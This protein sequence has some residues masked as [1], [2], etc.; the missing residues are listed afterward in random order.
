MFP[1]EDHNPPNFTQIE[2]FCKSV[3]SWLSLS[4]KN[5]AAV[6]CKAG[7]GRTGTMISCFY[8]Y[9][10]ALPD[11]F[12]AMDRFSS[13]RCKDSRVIKNKSLGIT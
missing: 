7:K 13:M 1:M 5:V 12:E 10:G 9:S 4:D 6:H 11:P 3:N 2:K 8:I